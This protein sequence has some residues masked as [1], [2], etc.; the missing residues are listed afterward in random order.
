MSRPY[1][2]ALY[3]PASRARALEKAR[4]L[5]CDAILFDLEDAVAP[6]E[7]AAARQTLATALADGGYGARA[8][9]VRINGLETEWGRADAEAAAAMDCDGVLVPKVA[10]PEMLD[11]VA[12]LVPG[13]PLWAMLETPAGVLAADRIAGHPELAGLVMGT[14]DLAKELGARGAARREPLL[15]ALQACLMAARAHGKVAID[16][17]Y[18]AFRDADGLSAECSQGRDM[19]FDGKSLIHPDQIAAANAAFGPTEAEVELARRQIA[20][21]EEAEARGEGVAVVDG[22]IVENLHVATARA[23]LA[24]A[25]AIAERETA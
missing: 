21:H 23:T 24:K 19:G 13:R 12:A 18:N 9:I 4:S 11:A 20:A 6:G 3:I 5:P 2:S 15:F 25:A 17:V 1:R 22:R 10:G 8:R 7:K 14:N 16:G